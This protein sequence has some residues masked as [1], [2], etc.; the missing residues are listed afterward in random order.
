MSSDFSVGDWVTDKNG[1][2]AM[3]VKRNRTGSYLIK[4]GPD[5]PFKTY[6]S[7]YLKEASEDRI[8]IAEGTAQQESVSVCIEDSLKVVDEHI[9]KLMEEGY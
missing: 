6:R 3:V 9:N 8:A 4:Y 7:T 5:G 1:Q 2:I